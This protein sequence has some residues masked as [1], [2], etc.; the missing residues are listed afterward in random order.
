MVIGRAKAADQNGQSKQCGQLKFCSK[1]LNILYKQR[2]ISEY[3]TVWQFN[4]L[5]KHT[6]I[7]VQFRGNTFFK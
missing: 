5:L 7:V 1:Y 4:E 3:N 2:D 6:Q